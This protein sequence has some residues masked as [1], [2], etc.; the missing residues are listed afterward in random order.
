[1]TTVEARVRGYAIHALVG[2]RHALILS[3]RRPLYLYLYLYSLYST[4]GLPLT[5]HP[6]RPAPRVLATRTRLLS[7]TCSL[8]WFPF[9]LLFALPRSCSPRLFALN[10]ALSRPTARSR[11]LTLPAPVPRLSRSRPR[12]AGCHPYGIHACPHFH[13]FC[14]V[15]ERLGGEPNPEREVS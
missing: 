7:P 6:P 5:P 4:V 9:A 3:L 2:E 13:S 1:M 14:R 10:L 12:A 11:T 8:P 15:P